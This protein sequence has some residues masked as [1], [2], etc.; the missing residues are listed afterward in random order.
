MPE[1]LLN[2]CGY[3]NRAR[4]SWDVQNLQAL[5]GNVWPRLFLQVPLTIWPIKREEQ[6]EETVGESY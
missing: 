6:R 3:E 2:L 1:K 4:I 5:G